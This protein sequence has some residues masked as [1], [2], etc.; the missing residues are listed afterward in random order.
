MSRWRPPP[1]RSLRLTRRGLLLLGAQAGIMGALAWRMRALQVEDAQRYRLLAEEN[2]I[3]IRLLPPAR[4]QIFDRNGAPLAVNSQNYRVVL[5]REQA[6]DVEDTLDRLGRLIRIEPHERERVLRD[7][8]RKSSFVPVTVTEHL[9]WEDFARVNANAPALPGIDVEVGL[10]RYYPEGLSMAHVV[11]YVGR[12]SEKELIADE[13]RTPLFQIPDFHIGKSGVETRREDT[14]RGHA[15]L[16]RIEVNARGRKVRELTREEGAPG[17]DLQLTIDLELQR[18]AMDRLNGESAAVVAMDVTTGDLV[19]CASSPGFEPNQFVFGISTRNWRGLMDDPYRP[20]SN[21]TVSGLYPPGSTYKMVVALAALEAGVVDNVEKIFCNGRYK[22]GD[23]YFHCWSRGGHGQMTL[24]D[25]LA[26]SC[27]VYF[28]E[29]A[30]RVGVDAISDMAHRLGVGVRHDLPLP[31]VAE[32]VAPTRDWKRASYDQSWLIGDTLNAGIGQGYVLAS[33]LHLAVM[34]AR[35][36]TGRAV[37]PRLV[38]GEAG[39]PLPDPTPPPLDVNGAHLRM[40][41]EGM[42]AVVNDRRGTARRARIMAEGLAM[43]GKSGTSQVRRITAAE[44]AAG[45][46]RNEDLPWE[47]RDHALFVSFAPYDAPRYA[48]SVVVEHGGGGSSA[49]S[50]IAQDVIMRALW[51]GP[52][53]LSAYPADQQDRVRQQ[54]V[55]PRPNAPEEV[56][57]PEAPRPAGGAGRSRA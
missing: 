21:K 27:D 24:R 3:N 33:P 32:G 37:S 17:A 2:R 1:V 55:G 12:V 7:I 28:Y 40:V 10:T 56:D 13:G 34:T 23:R 6:G 57:G 54:R 16:S 52:P 14:L 42:W 25:A 47:R 48:V 18:Y 50:P 20:L 41:R 19:A 4:G 36:A 30:R 45:V 22:L 43:A 38:R 11:G 15:G 5:I 26:Q 35:I 31:V 46:I 44:R 29:I 53:P 39:R 49:A 51:G 8:R 9:D